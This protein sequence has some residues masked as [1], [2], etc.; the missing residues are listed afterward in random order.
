VWPIRLAEKKRLTAPGFIE[1][2]SAFGEVFSS[3]V[4][5]C[6]AEQEQTYSP[7]QVELRSEQ[8]AAEG[9]DG[10]SWDFQSLEEEQG[11][12]TKYLDSRNASLLTEYFG[13]MGP[14]MSIAQDVNRKRVWRLNKREA[15]GTK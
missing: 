11:L 7:S 8:I 2:A 6:G 1:I 10:Q 5:T 15:Q 13:S 4:D 14:R 3:A 12:L 9:C